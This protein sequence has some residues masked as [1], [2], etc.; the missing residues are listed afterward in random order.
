MLGISLFDALSKG[1]FG[2]SLRGI[3]CWKPSLGNYLF[4]FLSI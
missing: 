2:F 1:K 4:I 3:A